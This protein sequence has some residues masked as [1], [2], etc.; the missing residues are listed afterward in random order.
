MSASS[1]SGG[2][3]RR[4]F[5]S[6]KDALV[7]S[8]FAIVQFDIPAS[9]KLT[10]VIRTKLVAAIFGEALFGGTVLPAQYCPCGRIRYRSTVALSSPMLQITADVL[11]SD[12][13]IGVTL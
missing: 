11:I 10:L 13:I 4:V 3:G 7:S 5:G 6:Y 1:S 12:I 9:I 2:G 8:A